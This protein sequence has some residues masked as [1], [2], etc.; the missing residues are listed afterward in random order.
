MVISEQAEPNV[1][2]LIVRNPNRS[3]LLIPEGTLL[4]GGWQTRVVA[5]D[6]FVAAGAARNISVR[7]VEQGRWHGAGTGDAA[8]RH[9]VD[10]RAPVSVV[11]A[12]RGIGGAQSETQGKVWERVEKLEE[13]YGSRSTKSLL[14]LMSFQGLNER[15]GRRL[16]GSAQDEKAQGRRLD[17]NLI[18]QVQQIAKRSLP[19]Q[20]GVLIGIGGEPIALEIH[21]NPDSLS[22]Q[23]QQIIN[24][25]MVDAAT[26][27]WQPTAGVKARGFAEE[28]MY[29]PVATTRMSSHS[30]SFSGVGQGVDIRSIA[31]SRGNTASMHTTVINPRHQVVL[32]V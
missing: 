24:A 29:T 4:D 17:P 20:S 26:L 6:T 31:A 5:A 21:G 13:H 2:R 27:N 15:E 8:T 9:E 16:H 30:Q 14:D 10:G 12:L 23:I 7:C 32:A 3:G 25:A 28:I 1:E 22:A 11:A 19:G 18:A